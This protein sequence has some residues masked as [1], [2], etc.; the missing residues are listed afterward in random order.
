MG[1]TRLP[2]KAMLPLHGRHCLDHVVSR[3]LAAELID[4][5]VVATTGHKQDDIIKRYAPK[6]GAAVY[7]GSE[8]DVLRRMYRAALENDASIIVRVTA[9]CPLIDPRTLDAVVRERER[10]D[11]DYAANILERTFPRGLDVEAFT[12]S[13]FQKVRRRAKNPSHREHVTPY[14]HEHPEKFNLV[15][16]N[17]AEVYDKP[18]LQDRTDI[19]LTL[20][21][22]ADYELLDTVYSGISYEEFIDFEEVV[23]YIDDND[24]TGINSSVQQ[25]EG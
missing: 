1:S 6:F 17:S 22:A 9:D 25:K 3:T 16:V 7:R 24:L 13:S 14:Y 5:V 18:A 12:F 23:D 8:E 2:G 4:H 21:E 19:R 10:T 20:D 15:N 11:A